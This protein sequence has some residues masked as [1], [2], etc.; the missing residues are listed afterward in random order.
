MLVFVLDV[1]DF[2]VVEDVVVGLLDVDEIVVVV[3]I[4]LV[5]VFETDEVVVPVAV[6]GGAA[7]EASP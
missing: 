7:P 5:V 3:E 4:V 6:A 2:T 1:V